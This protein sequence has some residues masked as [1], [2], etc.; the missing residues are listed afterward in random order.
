MASYKAYSKENAKEKAAEM[1]KKGY[2]CSI[3]PRK[4]KGMWGISVTRK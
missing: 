2:Q 3:Y 4:K 1:R